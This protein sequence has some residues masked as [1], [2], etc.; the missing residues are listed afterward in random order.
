[1]NVS[2]IVDWYLRCK[3]ARI[4]EKWGRLILRVLACESISGKQPNLVKSRNNKL[5]YMNDLN[6]HLKVVYLIRQCILV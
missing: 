5:R 3:G 6:Y 4:I 1:M 2:D